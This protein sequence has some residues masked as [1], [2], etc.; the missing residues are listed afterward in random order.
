LDIQELKANKQFA[1]LFS[2]EG[3][4]HTGVM[5]A[6]YP[7]PELA[8]QIA[9]IP[10][11]STPAEELHVTLAYC[12]D[13]G[14][15]TDA[16][17]SAAILSAQQISGWTKP[18][19]GI[20]GGLG[21][22]NA[23]DSSDAKDVM[24]ALV[25]VPELEDLQD[26]LS[27]R[28]KE[29][30]AVCSENH[31]F[32]PHMTL[33]Y[34]D[35]G[36]RSPIKGW[37]TMSVTFSDI[38][39]VVGDNKVSFPLSGSED[40][41]NY[42]EP[43]SIYELCKKN[44]T[45]QLFTEV[46]AFVEPPEWLPLLPKPGMFKH[47]SYGEV[48]ITDKRNA[49]FVEN[50][51][52][53]VY[54]HRI[55]VDAEHDLKA[56][57]ALGWITEARQNNDG[58]VDGKTEW[59]ERGKALLRDNRFGFVSPE[60]YDEWVQPATEESYKDVLIGAALVKRPFFKQGSLRPL[61]ASE[62]GIY[63]LSEEAADVDAALLTNTKEK[64]MAETNQFSELQATLA[65]QTKLFEEQSAKFA[66]LENGL[67]TADTARKAAEDQA[68]L[69][70]DALLKTQEALTAMEAEKRTSRFAEMCREWQGSKESH[71]KVLDLL[72]KTF[73]EDSADFKE[74]VQSNRATAEQVKTSNL[75][76][77]VGS[78]KPAT[79]SAQETL[80]ALTLKAMTEQKLSQVDAMAF[81]MNQNPGLYAAYGRSVEQ[82]V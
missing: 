6:L 75:F 26:D 49:N 63:A 20:L 16:Q 28:M 9:G 37:A 77:E 39:V 24:V 45:W 50:V 3:A 21:R 7:T 54:Q 14:G 19:S 17:I 61:I 29:L 34:I 68:K 62:T 23:S 18:L 52:K 64:E 57:G 78:S 67:K 65:T 58:S 66:E 48:N 10:G 46:S 35:T 32:T 69:F 60:W 79:G 30:G 43:N 31:G 4:K 74:Y 15:L 51:N 25:D 12:G 73:G 38:W 13:V 22:F 2:T 71:L 76:A 27:D 81:V 11:V 44:G 80:A 55:P 8:Q 47:P 42:S 53:A 33:A 36:K 82:K 56:S 5:V 70:S 41:M 72:A 1:E 40:T 59:N